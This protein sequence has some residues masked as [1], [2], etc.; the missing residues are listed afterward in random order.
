MIRDARF[1]LCDD[2]FQEE[3]GLGGERVPGEGIE[4]FLELVESLWPFRGNVAFQ[5]LNPEI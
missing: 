3:V 5:S 4:L 2:V 1:Y